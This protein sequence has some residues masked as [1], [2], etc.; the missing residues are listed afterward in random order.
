MCFLCFLLR[1]EQV[2]LGGNRRRNEWNE[3]R[4]S[5]NGR[6]YGSKSQKR[7]RKIYKDRLM[8]RWSEDTRTAEIHVKLGQYLLEKHEYL[9]GKGTDHSLSSSI[10]SAF[11]F[12][13]FSI[14]DIRLSRRRLIRFWSSAAH[15]MIIFRKFWHVAPA[16][17]SYEHAFMYVC[18]HWNSEYRSIRMQGLKT[19]NFGLLDVRLHEHSDLVDHVTRIFQSLLLF[20][21]A[22]SL[23][24]NLHRFGP[25]RQSF[26]YCFDLFTVTF[27]ELEHAVVYTDVSERSQ[28]LLFFHF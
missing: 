26:S 27:F 10:K 3:W 6:F 23:H 9:Q 28:N 20:F 8:G 25:L 24:D 18:R 2:Q 7:N 22:R 16:V 1:E 14:W 5:G 15:W 13:A 12:S 11:V 4:N 21:I 17:S 19:Y